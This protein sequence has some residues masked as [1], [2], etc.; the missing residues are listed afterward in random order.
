MMVDLYYTDRMEGREFVPFDFDPS[1][2]TQVNES[3]QLLLQ[4][5]GHSIHAIAPH[6]FLEKLLASRGYS[7]IPISA[8]EF[9]R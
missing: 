2:P 7:S 3:V 9:N 1:G 8:V 6:E 5:W 4:K